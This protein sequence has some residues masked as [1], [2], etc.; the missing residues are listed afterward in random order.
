MPSYQVITLQIRNN[1][2]AISMP[3]LRECELLGGLLYLLA[4][5]IH[6]CLQIKSMHIS[7]QLFMMKH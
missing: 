3:S 1:M 6:I 7:C 2:K 5:Y 4:F